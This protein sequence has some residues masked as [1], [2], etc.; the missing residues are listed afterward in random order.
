[1]FHI[2]Y[3][4]FAPNDPALHAVS[5]VSTTLKFWTCD[6][7]ADVGCLNPTSLQGNKQKMGNY[8]HNIF[9]FASFH[10]HLRLFFLGWQLGICHS[11][12][13]SFILIHLGR[14]YVLM[15]THNKKTSNEKFSGIPPCFFSFFGVDYMKSNIITLFFV[16][17]ARTTHDVREQEAGTHIC[18]FVYVFAK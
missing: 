4:L 13:N 15:L 11:P 14:S 17:A 18:R 9:S 1:M 8:E 7:A 10:K 12:S 16:I 6:I 3:F 5:F 2:S